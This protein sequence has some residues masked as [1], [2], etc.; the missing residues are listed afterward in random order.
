MA[1]NIAPAFANAQEDRRF[2]MRISTAGLKKHQSA[3]Q[4]ACLQSPVR[5]VKTIRLRGI[6]RS[7]PKQLIDKGIK[8]I[9]LLRHPISVTDSWNKLTGSGRWEGGKLELQ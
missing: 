1:S 7:I 5:I 8:V 3:I 2:R 4:Q 9:H 6:Y